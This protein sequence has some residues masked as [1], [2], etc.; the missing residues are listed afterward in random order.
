MMKDRL[1]RFVRDNREDFDVFE[2]RADL[3]KDLEKE[4]GHKERPLW[5]GLNT[6][7]WMG[8]RMIWQIAA[9]IALV[10]GLGGF[11]YFN[12]RYGVTEQPEIVALSP[13]YARTVT[14][15]TRLIEDKRTELK[16]ILESDPA[17]YQQFAADLD[18]L[19]KTY[20]KLKQE[21]PKTPNQEIMIQAMV[22]NLRTQIDLL[23]QQLMIIQRIKQQNHEP[24]K[25]PV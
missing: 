11:W 21:L 10:V 4:L 7:S 1:E 19:E 13:T 25:N 24:N 14:Q 5:M 8:R 16:T 17:L 2:P 22:E 12:A 20:Q 23:N 15:Y 3:W 9:S 6:P 18:R